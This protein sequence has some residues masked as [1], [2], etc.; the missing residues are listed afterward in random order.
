LSFWYA[1]FRLM[2]FED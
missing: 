1:Q 2:Y